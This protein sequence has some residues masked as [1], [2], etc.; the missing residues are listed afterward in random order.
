MEHITLKMIQLS[1]H[2]TA[3]EI[4]YSNQYGIITISEN[5]TLRRVQLRLAT[6]LCNNVLEPIRRRATVLQKNSKMIISGGARNIIT[7]E[8][9][10][11]FNPILPSQT[12]DHSFMNPYW[13]LGVGATDFYI[14][15]FYIQA[16]EI[17]F[18]WTVKNINP[19]TYGQI[20]IY[21]ETTH[22]FI[23]V[24]N[25]KSVLGKVGKAIS[26][27]EDR[28]RLVYIKGKG[29]RPFNGGF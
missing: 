8:A 2:F 25:P 10:K 11:R 19:E 28:K 13:S 3:S 20:I 23:H 21:P 17:L 29:F 6:Q 15:G 12:S 1:E 18:K 4:F 9:M 27:P 5:P 26:I 16:M 7:H 14:P 22:S 24:S